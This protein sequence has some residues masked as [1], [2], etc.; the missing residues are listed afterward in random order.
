[1]IKEKQELAALKQEIEALN[2]TIRALTSQV[3]LQR[4]D[5]PG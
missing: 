3:P 5:E 2:A 4:G 1:M